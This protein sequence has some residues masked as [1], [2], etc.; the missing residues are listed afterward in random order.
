MQKTPSSSRFSFNSID[1][2]KLRF[3]VHPSPQ[4]QVP[5]QPS[6][7]SSY[8]TTFSK[9]TWANDAP[10]SQYP[11]INNHEAPQHV[12]PQPWS[13][14]AV[15]PNNHVSG[16]PPP[17][18]PQ[19]YGTALPMFIDPRPRP[20]WS[21][22]KQPQRSS[23]I[24]KAV[25]PRV[26]PA[27]PLYY[28]PSEVA[29]RNKMSHQVYVSQPAEYVHKRASPRYMDEFSRPYAVFIFKYRSKGNAASSR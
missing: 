28:V 27:E 19:M 21:T 14:H 26:E 25:V 6:S 24:S 17:V 29:Q 1:S 10:N 8:K 9:R 4:G 12:T 16:S 20:H 3:S 22:W 23:S 5:Q 15:E 7:R 11:G 2:Y 18:A 13:E